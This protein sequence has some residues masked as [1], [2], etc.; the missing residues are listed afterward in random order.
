MPK[1]LKPK[2]INFRSFQHTEIA[3]LRDELAAERGVNSL[4]LP[5]TVMEAIKFFRENR[6]KQEPTE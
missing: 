6:P 4:S 3:D 5:D 1:V 2:P